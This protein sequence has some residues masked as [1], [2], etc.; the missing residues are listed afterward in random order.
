[1]ILRR[2]TSADIDSAGCA[3]REKSTTGPARYRP[4]VATNLWAQRRELAFDSGD[5]QCAAWFSAPPGDGP[6]PCVV[7]GHGFSLTRHDSLPAYAEVLATAGVAVLAFDYRHFGDSAGSPRQ[8]FRRRKQ[9][10]DFRSAVECA[11][12]Q[13]R[14]DPDQIVV[15]GFSFGG[16]HA[17]ELGLS[18]SRLAAAIVLCPFVDGLQR[19]RSTPL[20]LSSW[21]IPRAIADQL[22]RHTTVPVTAPAG[23]HGAMTLPGE[24]DGFAATVS[25]DSPWRNEITPAVFLT[26]GFYRPVRRARQLRLPLWVGMAE[27]DITTSGE[28]V[29]RLA[30]MADRGELHRYAGA[31]FDPFAEPAAAEIAADQVQFL[32]RVHILPSTT[33]TAR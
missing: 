33:P 27:S 14:V 25:D 12:R 32:R 17:I 3:I 11:R 20:R 5:E 19:V 26:I 13:P 4:A 23:Q 9:V 16:A 2:T 30:T 21:M 15:W 18:D 6:H 31:H 10:E 1:L 24:A 29:A 28:A 7:M 8:Q 22:G